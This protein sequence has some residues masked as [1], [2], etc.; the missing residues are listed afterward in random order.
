MATPSA[1]TSLVLLLLCALPGCSPSGAPPTNFLE[2]SACERVTF[3]KD[4]A[5][6]NSKVLG[7]QFLNGW[8]PKRNDDWLRAPTGQASIL[9]ATDGRAQR[10]VLDAEVGRGDVVATAD[11]PLPSRRVDGGLA[12]DVDALPAGLHTIELELP[13][14]ARARGARVQSLPPSASRASAEVVLCAVP[15]DYRVAVQWKRGAS[16]QVRDATET[17]LDS[18]TLDRRGE[19]EIAPSGSALTVVREPGARLALTVLPEDDRSP[20]KEASTNGERPDLV[21]VYVQDALRA[22]AV[23]LLPEDSVWKTLSREGLRL[24]QHRSVAPNTLPST[25]ALFTGR[26]WATAGGRALPAEL[27]TLAGAYREAGFRT[28]LF[29]NNPWIS[30]A[31]GMDRGFDHAGDALART[32]EPFFDDVRRVHAAALDWLR[33]ETMDEPVFLYLHVL[34]PH[35]PYDPPPRFAELCPTA[36]VD[37]ST[38][39]LRTVRDRRSPLAPAAKERLRC[40]YQGS[41]AYADEELAAFLRELQTL[42]DSSPRSQLTILTS[43]H[44]EEFFEHDGVLHGYTLFEEQ[45]R[46]PLVAHWPGRLEPESIDEPTSTLNVHDALLTVTRNGVT[47]RFRRQLTAPQAHQFAAAASVRG[48]LFSLQRG[49]SKVIWAPRQGRNWGQGQGYGR[50]RDAVEIFSVAK[51]PQEARGLLLSEP[52]HLGMWL[53]LRRRVSGAEGRG[54]DAETV[55]PELEKRLRA[56]GY[57]DG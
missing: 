14:G 21:L 31:Y 34:H 3:S 8:W 52:S 19:S 6:P 35:N 28:G 12:I 56:L 45:L 27:P 25:K 7:S 18:A 47:D 1:R 33:S 20:A 2:T 48:G 43:D 22:D 41:L 51:D 11:G 15:E 50:R 29:S 53:D 46:I 23:D 16:W 44:G 49:S 39:T 38:K 40:L 5:L 42:N 32:P 57:L 26:V 36:D 9:L 10:L 30:A 13:P 17:L 55:D 37:G 54:V 4:L 24:A